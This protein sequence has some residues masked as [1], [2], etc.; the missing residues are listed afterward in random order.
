MTPGLHLAR[1]FLASLSPAPPLPADEA[2]A[3]AYLGP[4]ES[5]L[6]HRMS[7]PDRR[8]AV[9]V[10]RA[11][12][13][14]LGPDAAQEVVAAALLH[15]VGKVVSGFGTFR[16]VGATLVWEGLE[17]TRPDRERAGRWSVADRAGIRRLGQYRRHPELGAELL[18][19][20]GAHELTVA[21]AREHH[22][23]PARWS[24]PPDIGAVLKSCDDD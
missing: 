10:A 6:W 11:V 8:H 23:R 24:V 5:E 21:W 4:G 22:R 2:W 20:A 16:R 3:L 19:A 1:R 15:D 17:R 12:V 14:D 13:A 7:N 9:G 18:V